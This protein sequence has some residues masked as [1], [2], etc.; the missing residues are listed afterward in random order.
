MGLKR[1]KL[2]PQ[3]NIDERGITQEGKFPS[4]GGALSVYPGRG[5]RQLYARLPSPG[6]PLSSERQRDVVAWLKA[7]N[8]LWNLTAPQL[9]AQYL[10]QGKG[11]WLQ[12]RDIFTA[13]LAGRLFWLDFQDADR[14]RL[15]P[16][17]RMVR[18]MSYSLDIFSISQ[19][20][21]LYRAAD[22]WRAVE[23]GTL[24]QVLRIGA[25]G[26]PEW[27]DIQVSGGGRPLVLWAGAAELFATG[28]GAALESFGSDWRSIR[29]LGYQ[30][31]GVEV[32]GLLP[33]E[34]V[35]FRPSAAVG[36]ATADAGVQLWRWRW[37]RAALDGAI[38]SSGEQSFY[39]SGWSAGEIR[40]FLGDSVALASTLDATV[41]WLRLERLGGDS[42][43][44]S[45]ANSSLLWF[46]ALV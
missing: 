44:T 9:R 41:L 14:L 25:E 35:T 11:L 24:G 10:A 21:M 18:D 15:I 37:R 43:D 4:L 34:A 23:G 31:S 22:R 19:G 28:Q 2:T 27:A 16:T 32:V 17:F 30:N 12:P 46:G 3:R 5:G 38:L 6:A 1:R 33:V 7:S 45:G 39:S 29:L 40:H 26:V 36:C 20:A 13:A 42:V 8:L